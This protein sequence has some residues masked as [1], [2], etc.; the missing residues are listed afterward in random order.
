MTPGVRIV[1]IA[2]SALAGVATATFLTGLIVGNGVFLGGHFLLGLAV[3]EPAIRIVS[4]AGPALIAAGVGLAVL[5]AIGWWL[6]ARRRSQLRAG[7]G[8]DSASEALVPLDWTDACCP[9]CLALAVILPART[10]PAP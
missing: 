10:A 1:A 7:A 4:G 5:G 8:A 9:A 3:G 6:I 2:S